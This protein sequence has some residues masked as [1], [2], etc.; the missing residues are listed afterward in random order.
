[1]AK[2]RIPAAR[3]NAAAF[4]A[5]LAATLVTGLAAVGGLQHWHGQGPTGGVPGTS[6]AEVPAPA[7][8]EDD[9]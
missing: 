4:A 6:P 7:T 5:A 2:E 1:M 9:D 3:R 8:S